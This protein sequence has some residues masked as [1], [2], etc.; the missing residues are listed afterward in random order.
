[1]E[2]WHHIMGLHGKIMVVHLVMEESEKELHC[3]REESF[4]AWIGSQR[5]RITG[6]CPIQKEVSLSDE[7]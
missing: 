6:M 4:P 7:K 5:H 1:M 2:A 3:F